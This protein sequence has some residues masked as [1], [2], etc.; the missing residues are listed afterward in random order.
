MGP[1]L[2]AHIP[3]SDQPDERF[4]HEGRGLKHMARTLAPQVPAGELSQFRLDQRYEL[5]Q[6]RPVPFSPGDEQ[7]RYLRRR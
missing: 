4:V 3:P 2:P 1:V 5:V 7:P 6:S